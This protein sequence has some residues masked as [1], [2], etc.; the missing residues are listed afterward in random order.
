VTVLVDTSVLIDHL[1]GNGAA[2]EAL[3]KVVAR[4]DRLA[5]SVAVKVE[6]LAGMRPDEERPTRRLLGAMEWFAVDDLIAEQAG[7]LANRFLRSHPGVDP[8]DYIIAATAI[9]H[10]ASLWTKNLK[11][12]PMFP[13]L[14]AP[15]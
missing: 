9:V 8:V 14:R 10:E 1:R 4:G 7:E 6:I 5:A 11:H 12:F 13:D 2:R 3:E 15:Y